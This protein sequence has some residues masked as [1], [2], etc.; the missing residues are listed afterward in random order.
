MFGKGGV[1]RHLV[2]VLFLSSLSLG[3]LGVEVSTDLGKGIL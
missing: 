3:P 1:R 2:K